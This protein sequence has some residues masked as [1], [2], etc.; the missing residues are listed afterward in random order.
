MAVVH[1]D[2]VHFQI[3]G[4]DG[5]RTCAITKATLLI[6]AR[7]EMQDSSPEIL[8]SIFQKYRPEIEALAG[9]ILD[10]QADSPRRIVITTT[11]F[12]SG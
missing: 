4:P 11:Q 3:G 6:R 7:L 9:A 2:F 8:L 5:A 1:G 12:N 10:G